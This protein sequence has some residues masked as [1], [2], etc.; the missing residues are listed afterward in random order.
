[1]YRLLEVFKQ[2]KKAFIF[3]VG[4]LWRKCNSLSLFKVSFP[5]VIRNSLRIRGYIQ[6]LIN[7]NMDVGIQNKKIKDLLEIRKNMALPISI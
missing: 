7:P 4:F 2:K 6:L 5:C 3:L 1:M